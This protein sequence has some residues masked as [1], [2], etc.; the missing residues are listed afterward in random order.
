MQ[1]EHAL[2][3]A[4]LVRTCVIGYTPSPDSE[5]ENTQETVQSSETDKI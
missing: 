4:V 3:L 2:K 5:N 1:P